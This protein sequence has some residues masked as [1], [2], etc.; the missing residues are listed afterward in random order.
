M[1]IIQFL[2]IIWARAPLILACTIFTFL[3]GVIVTLIVQPRYQATSR[4]LMNVLK[5]DPV[6]GEAPEYQVM[7]AYVQTQQELVKD[8][9]VT[10]PVVDKLGW[11][12]DPRKIADYQAR[13]ASDTRDFRRWL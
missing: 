13:P 5:Q 2:R 12:S 11:L 4:V 7:D 10:G 3:G 8:Y 1:S 6:T 9:Q